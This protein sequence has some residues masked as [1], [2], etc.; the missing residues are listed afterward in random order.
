MTREAEG[1]MPL[2]LNAPLLEM[3]TAASAS[4]VTFWGLSGGAATLYPELCLTEFK[5]KFCPV[6]LW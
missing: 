4:M 3:I 2:T 5:S 1:R 6:V